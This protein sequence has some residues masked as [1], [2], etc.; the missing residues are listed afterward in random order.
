MK[1]PNEKEMRELE[2]EWEEERI[3]EADRFRR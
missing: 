3:R 1:P 2:R